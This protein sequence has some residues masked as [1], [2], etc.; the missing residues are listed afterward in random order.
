[1]ESIIGYH[2]V[3]T[4]ATMH[5]TFSERHTGLLNIIVPDDNRT[6]I[7]LYMYPIGVSVMWYLT[8]KLQGNSLTRAFP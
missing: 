7:I 8:K 5:S 6:T 1:M 4:L 3:W 2:Q